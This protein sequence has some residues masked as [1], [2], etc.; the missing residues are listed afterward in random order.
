MDLLIGIGIGIIFGALI[1]FIIAGI[2]SSNSDN[3]QDAYNNG[4]KDGKNFALEDVNNLYNK[5]KD[6]VNGY[7]D[8]RH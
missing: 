8:D 5:Y 7:N 6:M 1:G 3:L 2:M 4:F